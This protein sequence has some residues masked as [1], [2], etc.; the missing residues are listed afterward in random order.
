[1]HLPLKTLVFTHT[2]ML[3]AVP[4]FPPDADTTAKPRSF[5]FFH[6]NLLRL[7]KIGEFHPLQNRKYIK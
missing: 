1:M 6:R 7:I 3:V 5:S 4:F 2:L